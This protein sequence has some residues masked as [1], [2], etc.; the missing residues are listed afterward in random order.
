MTHILVAT[1]GYKEGLDTMIED[2]K[3]ACMYKLKTGS[4]EDIGNN[5]G[6]S[7][8]ELRF[9]DIVVKEDI[10]PQFLADLKNYTALSWID[11]ERPRRPEGRSYEGTNPYIYHGVDGKGVKFKLIRKV[12]GF[13]MKFANM[14]L[15]AWDKIQASKPEENKITQYLEQKKK[16]GNISSWHGYIFTIG[17]LP[18]GFVKDGPNKGRENT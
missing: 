17:E 9:Y 1:E 11:Q 18:D 4:K 15:V 2:L 7:I 12:M 13:F 8:R 14:R 5:C 3:G 16:S 10:K 6:I